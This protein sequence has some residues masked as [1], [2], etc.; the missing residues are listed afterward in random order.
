MPP[1]THTHTHKK[2]QLPLLHWYRTTK[3]YT[4]KANADSKTQVKVTY[5]AGNFTQKYL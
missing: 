1:S 5:K 3:I 2:I 4:G